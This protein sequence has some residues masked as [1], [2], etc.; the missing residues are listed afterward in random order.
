MFPSRFLITRTSFLSIPFRTFKSK[1]S[2]D[3]IYPNST[4]DLSKSQPIPKSDE[5]FS[6]YIPLDQL[7]ITYAKSSGP[8]GQHVNKVNTKVEVRFHVASASWIPTA[9][10]EKLSN[11]HSNNLTKDGFLILKSDKTRMQ[12][13]NLADCMDKLRCYIREAEKPPPEVLPETLEIIK[14]R[15]ERASAARLRQ[16]R[17]RSSIKRMKNEDLNHIQI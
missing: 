11:L 1:Y 17:I 4:L 2:L 15:I 9:A 10:R 8:G 13:L 12:T 16:K 7:S 6:G 14:K 5:K 3:K